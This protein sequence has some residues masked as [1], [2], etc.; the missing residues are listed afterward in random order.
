ME[1]DR[2]GIT[3]IIDN[4]E[5]N[6]LVERRIHENDRRSYRIFLTELGR[7]MKNDLISIEM[8]FDKISTSGLSDKQKE[9]F[10]QVLRIIGNNI[11]KYFD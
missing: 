3:R 5:K 10:K 2:T 6:G 4:M 8:E 7:N 1:K 9:E 11:S